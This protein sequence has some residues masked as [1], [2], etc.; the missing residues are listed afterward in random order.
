MAGKS[1][2]GKKYPV[3]INIYG[4]PNYQAVSDE[5]FTTLQEVDVNPVIEV[6]FAHRGSGD[7]G[8]QGLN[9][10]HRNLGK[11]E[12]TDYIAWI[13]WLRNNPYVDTSKIMITGGSYGGYLTAM[14]L[15]YGAE[16]FKYGISS[17]PVTDWSLYDSHYT[18]R[19]MDLPK[20]NPEGYRF[21]SVMTH[22]GN[23]QNYGPSM[24]L[25]QHGTMDDNV[26][27]QNAYQLADTLQ[28]LGKPFEL[29]VYPGQRHGFL[30]PKSRFV[31][32]ARNSFKD[33]YLFNKN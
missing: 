29:M 3:A 5:W 22:V 12:M 27:I 26:H 16:Y 24:L 21:G 2:K 13:K 9:F 17:F 6:G 25:L 18:E 10:L 32:K 14:A 33:R 23:Y 15:T 1:G 30:G 28:K 20:D 31:L 11:W 4:G 7:L 8:K 19:Y